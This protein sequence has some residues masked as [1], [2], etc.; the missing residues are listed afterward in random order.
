MRSVVLAGGTK[1]LELQPVLVLLLVFGGRI[2]PILTFWTLQSY[3]FTHIVLGTGVASPA[4]GLLAFSCLT[5]N[6]LR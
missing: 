5:W 4:T 2:I 1:L 6:A 3:D